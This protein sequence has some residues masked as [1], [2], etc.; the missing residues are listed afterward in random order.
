MHGMGGGGGR[1]GMGA[2]GGGGGG[3]QMVRTVTRCVFRYSMA[4]VGLARSVFVPSE[5][6]SAL[7]KL[8]LSLEV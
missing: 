4:F 2:G 8:G 3:G 5:S 6:I 7:R 1:A